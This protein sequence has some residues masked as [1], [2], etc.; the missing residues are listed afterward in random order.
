MKN[1]V[2]SFNTMKHKG[3]SFSQILWYWM[4]EL[5]SAF[6]LISLPPMFDSWVITRLG[7]TTIYGALAMGVNFLH[8]LIKLAEAI[9]VASIAI[10][11]RHNGAQEYEKCGEGLGDTFWTTCIFGCTQFVIIFFAATHIY[12]WFGVP[13]E[14]IRI[15]APFLQL[16]SLGLFFTFMTLGLL[17]FMR[18][19][20]N[21][22]IPM[23]INLLGIGIFMFFDYSLVLGKFG[24]A[25][26]GLMGSAY[27]SLIQN[28]LM[29]GAS[30]AYILGNPA[31][32]K[33]FKKVFFMFFN[34]TKMLRILNLSWPIIIDKSMIAL[35]YVWLSKMLATMGTYAIASYDV[36]KNLERSAFLP[37]MASAAVVTFLVS[38]SLG[39]QDPDGAVANIKKVYI[40]TFFT[41]LA[42][43]VILNINSRY[44]IS[45]FDPHNNFTDFAATVL[46]II[47]GMLF[48][49]FTQ[50]I[51]AGALRGA[52]DVKTVM[53]ARLVIC[54]LFFVPV[55]WTLSKIPGLTIV[56]RYALVYSSFYLTTG[57]IGI[58]YFYRIRSNAWK[59]RSL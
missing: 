48:L 11:G 37:V 59:K 10:I 42:G 41:V 20:K 8:S 23:L 31:Y 43:I 7:S 40:I 18:S 32:T 46:P 29:F 53:M 13:D 25:Q 19:I 45:I 34:P 17:G 24:F 44:F 22:K 36:I 9:P 1:I 35:S 3:E 50:V 55:S 16:K 28:F 56:T 39:A 49:D 5:V 15:G 12:S 57:L 38:N 14:M 52:G 30:L 4:P 27:A 33:Y 26:H 6:I 58:W 54:P 2:A 51:L 47:S 21:T